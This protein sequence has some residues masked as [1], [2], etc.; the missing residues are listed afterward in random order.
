MYFY[1]PP[2]EGWGKVIVSVCSHLGEVPVSGPRGGVSVSGLGGGV[3]G[4]NSGGGP[5]LRSGGYP[6]S[7]LGGRGVPVSGPG[8]GGTCSKGK[9]F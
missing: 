1:R 5:G 3:P 9:N 2:S 7:I 6:V 4:L 8:R